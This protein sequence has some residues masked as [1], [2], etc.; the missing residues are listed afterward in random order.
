MGVSPERIQKLESIGFH[1]RA[2]YQQPKS[3]ASAAQ[4]K[5]RL[6]EL[7]AYQQANGDC[8]VNSHTGGKL[9][10]WVARQRDTYRKGKMA[11]DRIQQLESIGFDWG[12]KNHTS[13]A[14]MWE[15]KIE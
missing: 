7:V 8:N 15:E 6:N 2:N 1:W 11:T 13:Y 9:G 3:A 4:W 12:A 14:K 5:E 10:L